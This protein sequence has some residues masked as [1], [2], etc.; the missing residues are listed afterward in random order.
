MADLPIEES[1]ARYD[2]LHV[3]YAMGDLERAARHAG[4]MLAPAELTSARVWRG[5]AMD[6]NENVRSAKG[7]WRYARDFIE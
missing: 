6:A 1:H 2:L 3:L 4:A 7:D 5:R